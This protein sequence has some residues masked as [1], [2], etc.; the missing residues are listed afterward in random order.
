[1]RT[2]SRRLRGLARPAQLLA[3]GLALACLLCG[4]VQELSEPSYDAAKSGCQGAPA[5]LVATAQTKLT[6]AGTLRNG[7][8]APGDDGYTF[9]TTELWRRGQDEHRKGDLLTFATK[10][11]S[12]TEMVAVDQNARADTSWSA[13]PF[14]VSAKGGRESRSCANVKRGTT[15]A[16]AS[17]EQ[18]RGGQSPGLPGTKK[19]SDL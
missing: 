7:A 19:C 12:Q 4:C 11:G 18:Q 13:A 14:G 3:L 16:Q 9:L 6:V 8:V 5:A 15:R 1:M 10:A 2:T 17:C